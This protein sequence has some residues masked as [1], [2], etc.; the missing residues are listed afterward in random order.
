[1]FAVKTVKWSAVLS[2]LG[3]VA[4]ALFA[5]GSA[6]TKGKETEAK[7]RLLQVGARIGAVVFIA[8]S[9]IGV[10]AV[11]HLA[12][13]KNLL[14]DPGGE[15]WTGLE[16]MGFSV[17]PWRLVEVTLGFLA[18]A[19]LFA[20]RFDINVFGLNQ[21]Y[22]NRLVRCYL[23]ATRWK[24]G[25]R[26]PNGF[27]GFD[28]KDDLELTDLQCGCGKW[29]GEPFRGPFPIINCALNLGGS[30]D[31]E[32][33][34][35]QSA[36][37][38]LTPL[39]RGA[40][41]PKVGYLPHPEDEVPPVTLGQAISISGA[42]ANPNMGYNTSPIVSFLLTMFN[43][44]LG[45][46]FRNPGQPD[47][48]FK[49]FNLNYLFLELF[50]L[51][52]E[53]RS[54]VN[55]S[56]GGHF[57]NLGIYE[58][59]RRRAK[60]IIACDGE[61]DPDLSF[62]SLGNLVRICQTDFGAQIDLDVASIRKNE[63][64]SLSRAHCAVGR[65]TY[66]NGG[67]GYLIYLKSSMTGDED[68]G[69][70]QYRAGHDTFPHES[71]ADQFFTEDQFEAYRRLGHHIASVTFRPVEG[72]PSVVAIASKLYD[73]WSP[74]GPGNQV[75]VQHSNEFNAL[76]EEIG[77]SEVL[78]GLF[79]ELT[80]DRAASEPVSPNSQELA[81]CMELLQL[82]EN[83]FFDLR[84]DEYWDHPDNRGWAMLFTMW[85]KSPK[86]KG[87][88]N[89]VRKTYGIRFEHFCNERLGLDSDRPIVRVF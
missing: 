73:L 86:F 29:D 87:T 52:T 62:G 14:A 70:E 31:L 25:S 49:F 30:S 12:L 84:L 5:G 37:F 51:A 26:R 36:S 38:S 81:A 88:W 4:G 10:A 22:R 74:L 20:W 39:G 78:A 44:R 16:G 56:D 89:K 40:S 83:I 71:T 41:R 85:A 7:A 42:A 53:D 3:T 32:V 54:W 69:I 75:F 58:L 24:P 68:I 19:L 67:Q 28:E 17:M 23:G 59:I 13:A 21:F 6:Q 79:A 43:V 46:W 45:W 9:I 66:S 50:G 33:K 15:Y 8:G 48:F 72:E 35:R 55:L 47:S 27:T 11:L 34:T 57:E 80:G 2:F 64:S 63:E 18:V 1:L 60:V 82:M 76:W 61:C 65:I 77:K